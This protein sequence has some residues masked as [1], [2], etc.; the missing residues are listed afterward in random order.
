MLS[1]AARPLLTL[2]WL[3]SALLL[4]GHQVVQW[5]LQLPLPVVDAYLD[6]VVGTVALLGLAQAERRLLS[7]W[8]HQR[9]HR[10]WGG[11]RRFKALEVL[12]LCIALALVS[13][14]LFPWL[15]A[16]QTGDWWDVL[17]IAV[18]A[19]LFWFGVNTR[20]D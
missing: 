8:L 16:R 7:S 4:V 12:G 17:A 10:F 13:E 19:L 11:W 14:L 9:G 18:G 2:T 15:D 1:F 3:L 6:P 20:V 5:V